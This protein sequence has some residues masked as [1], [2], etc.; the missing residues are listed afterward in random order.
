MDYGKN[1][2]WAYDLL[3]KDDQLALWDIATILRE[4]GVVN[5]SKGN[6]IFSFMAGLLLFVGMLWYF[7]FERFLF[8]LSRVSLT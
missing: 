3:V 8:N 1:V 4:C 7:G 5:V 6:L 2:I